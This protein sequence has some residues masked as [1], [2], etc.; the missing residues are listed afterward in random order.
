M[1]DGCR[2]Y[3]DKFEIVNWNS[4]DVTC[5]NERT[6][7]VLFKRSQ[8]RRVDHL[9]VDELERVERYII[10]RE[11]SDYFPE[12]IS[13]LCETNKKQTKVAQYVSQ[14]GFVPGRKSNTK[15]QIETSK[16]TNFLSRKEP[17]LD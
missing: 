6:S 17:Y 12:E 10:Q 13:Y 5:K 3:P 7:K 4:F 2:N 9:T 8:N 14:F 1:T 16:C 11:Q 15:I